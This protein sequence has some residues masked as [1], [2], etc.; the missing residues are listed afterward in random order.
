MKSPDMAAVTDSLEQSFRNFSLNHRLSSAAPSSAGVR[1]SPSSFSSS[2]SS[3]DD[4]PHL[5]LHQHNRFDTILELNSHISL[6]PFWEQCLDLKTGEVY[7]RNCRT[8]MKVKEDP[9]TAVAH[10]RDLYLEDDDGED[11][12]ESSSDGGSEESCS[13]SSYGGSRQQYPAE[14]V[15]D[16]LVVAGCKRCFMYFMV[17]KQVEDCPKCSSSRLV[18]FDR[19]DESNGFP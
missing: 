8:G 11:G 14:N 1:R 7:Y 15:E 6:P 10:S 2:S 16:V 5:P 17:P 18:H 12:D 4:E 13:S 3:S 9:R 19:S